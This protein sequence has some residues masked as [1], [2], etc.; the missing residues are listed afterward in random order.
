MNKKLILLIMVPFLCFVGAVVTGLVLEM[1]QVAIVLALASAFIPL[2][3]SA[4]VEQ[5]ENQ[6]QE[7][8]A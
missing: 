6:N 7:E 1:L 2:I 3:G 5:A 8:N 4:I